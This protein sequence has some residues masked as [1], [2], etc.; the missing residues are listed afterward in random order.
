MTK[1]YAQIKAEITR[2][3]KEAAAI[4]ATETAKVVAHIRES[5]ATFG[6]SVEQLFGQGAK[7]LKAATGK[8][9]GGSGKAQ[10]KGA[11]IAKYRDPKTGKTWTGFGKAPGWIAKARNRDKFLIE[12][13]GVVAVPSVKEATGPEAK[14]VARKARAVPT[15]AKKSSRTKRVAAA[16]VK[17]TAVQVPAKKTAFKKASAKKGV[18]PRK[19]V[20]SATAASASK[21][22]SVSNTATKT[23]KKVVSKAVKPQPAIKR[24]SRIKTAV[25]SVVG[26]AAPEGAET[27]VSAS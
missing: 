18:P 17:V 9:I 10:R 11:G 22:A 4:R 21:G 14:Q 13:P 20:P 16:A 15:P 12:Q 19:S 25:E 3:E 6:L 8:V 27:A 24:R 23:A 26:S 5:I 7:A 2:L 1:S